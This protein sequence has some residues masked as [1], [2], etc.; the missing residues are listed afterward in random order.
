MTVFVLLQMATKQEPS[1]CSWPPAPVWRRVFRKHFNSSSSSKW[2]QLYVDTS[3]VLF[4]LKT[5]LLVDCVPPSAQKLQLFLKDMAQE[6]FCSNKKDVPDDCDLVEIPFIRCMG[7]CCILTIGED[8]LLV[9]M[10]C[11][12][13]DWGLQGHSVYAAEHTH[14]PL[15]ARTL[16]EDTYTSKRVMFVDVT[17]G[18]QSPKLLED[19]DKTAVISLFM[20]WL[21]AVHSTSFQAAEK[22]DVVIIPC[23]T[24]ME[25]FSSHT[26]QGQVG[27]DQTSLLVQV[28]NDDNSSDHNPGS[29]MYTNCEENK[30]S[31]SLNVCTLFGQ[32][33]GYPVV[34]WFDTDRGHSLDMVELVCYSVICSDSTSDS[35]VS[36]SL[37][38]EQVHN[39]IMTK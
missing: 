24:S 39:I 18:L 22:T 37:S 10:N 1:S 3:C 27:H 35:T 12:A 14:M 29:N 4:G 28:D 11:L 15:G 34:Y 38:I 16:L 13:H 9:N 6:E 20:R 25:V 33:L 30:S 21:E 19:K 23:S 26:R 2:Y 17:K 31:T 8:V 36:L 7:N 32:L 5:A